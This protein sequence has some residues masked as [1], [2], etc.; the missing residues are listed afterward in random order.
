[1]LWRTQAQLEAQTLRITAGQRKFTLNA[2]SLIS[3]ITVVATILAMV[4]IL[5]KKDSAVSPA[6]SGRLRKYMRKR[7]E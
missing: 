4:Y 5:S 1:M 3:S 7:E 6:E 2:D